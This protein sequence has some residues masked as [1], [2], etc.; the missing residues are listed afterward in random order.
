MDDSVT[1]KFTEIF[2]FLL[3]LVLQG[4]VFLAINIGID[5]WRTVYYKGID[6]NEN[7][8]IERLQLDEKEDVLEHQTFTTN[9][10]NNSLQRDQNGNEYPIQANTLM[11]VYKNGVAAVNRNTFCVQKG[12]VFGLLGPNGAGKTSTFNIMTM[13][14]RRSG[15]NARLFNQDIDGLKIDGNDVTLGMCPQENSLWGDLTVEQSLNQI[16]NIVG[17]EQSEIDF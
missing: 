17:L 9:V 10:W 3:A 1:D 2:P 15:G 7:R 16:G 13:A 4:I 8:M 14:L 6:G 11:K 5:Y 12:E